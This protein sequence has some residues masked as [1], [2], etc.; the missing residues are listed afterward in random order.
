MGMTGYI[1]QSN[2]IP[3]DDEGTELSDDTFF[4]S[5]VLMKMNKYMANQGNFFCDH[6]PVIHNARCMENCDKES[7]GDGTGDIY[8][9]R[10]AR[11]LP[12]GTL[13]YNV[14]QRLHEDKPG[15]GHDGM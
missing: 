1:L 6:R 14:N 5:E 11:Q 4:N 3:M 9:Y 13:Q 7:V 15:V 8:Q 10:Q 12:D 2:Y